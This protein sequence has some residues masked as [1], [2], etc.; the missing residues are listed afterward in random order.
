[1]DKRT[2]AIVAYITFIGLIIALC[3]GDRDGARF[4]INQ[5]LVIWL[6]GLLSVVPVIGWFWGIFIAV[7]WVI[8]L[9]HA[10]NDDETPVPLI[11]NVQ[12]LK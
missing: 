2:T 1:M 7:C 3:V 10:I 9:I 12:I 5:A 6:F 8:G 4:H 11:G